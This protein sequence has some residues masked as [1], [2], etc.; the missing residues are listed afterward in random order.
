[1]ENWVRSA[2]KSLVQP[3]I[4]DDF[5][6][7]RTPFHLLLTGRGAKQSSVRELTLPAVVGVQAG[8]LLKL[9]TIQ[10]DMAQRLSAMDRYERRALSRRT[11]P[12][13]DP[14]RLTPTL[15]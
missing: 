2:K 12:Q 6:L 1:M 3:V 11:A 8:G 15:Q 7:Y 4:A 10:S 5:I 9:A 13:P 14:L